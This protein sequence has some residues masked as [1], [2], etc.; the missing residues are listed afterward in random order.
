M[1]TLRI[2]PVS[3]EFGHPRTPRSPSPRS[4]DVAHLTGDSGDKE[5]CRWLREYPAAQGLTRRPRNG[6]QARAKLKGAFKH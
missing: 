1:H 3:S 2:S 5:P 6:K 4:S